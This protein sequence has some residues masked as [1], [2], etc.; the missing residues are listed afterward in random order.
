MLVDS[1]TLSRDLLENELL[2]Y[3][4]R[5]NTGAT[6]CERD[7]RLV[8]AYRSFVRFN[9]IRQKRELLLDDYIFTT[10]AKYLCVNPKLTYDEFKVISNVAP[11]AAKK[12]FSAKCFLKF[13]KD[14]TGCIN[15]EDF[16]HFIE[17]SIEVENIMLNLMDAVAPGLDPLLTSL[18]EAQLEVFL[19]KM[20]PEV[21]VLQRMHES[22]HDYYAYTASQKFMFFLDGRRTNT[23]PV[24]KIAHSAAMEELLQLRKLAQQVNELGLTEVEAQVRFARLL[25]AF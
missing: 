9:V 10:L 11:P 18:T 3:T 12:Y 13:P 8:S 2:K 19:L 20:I 7:R 1:Q 14:E 24:K 16:V 21:D 17:R 15:S 22:F 4:E 25:Y 5:P 23:I 6:Y